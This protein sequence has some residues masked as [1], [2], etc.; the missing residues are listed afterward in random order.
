MIFYQ[1]PENL[2]FILFTLIE[3]K[4]IYCPE[5]RGLSLDKT[6]T[7]FLCWARSLGPVDPQQ[8]SA[9]ALSAARDR[10]RG[11]LAERKAATPENVRRAGSRARWSRGH[12]WPVRTEC[13]DVET[14]QISKVPFSQTPVRLS[15]GTPA[16][17]CQAANHAGCWDPPA[18]APGFFGPNCFPLHFLSPL[19]CR[20][21]WWGMENSIVSQIKHS[22]WN[23]WSGILK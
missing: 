21:V 19:P 14:P 7:W 8:L 13:R 23:N 20:K 9:L 1:N 4:F 16:R 12:Q 10:S 22:L 17:L 2:K 11:L 18:A 3:H 15:L 5:G 6:A